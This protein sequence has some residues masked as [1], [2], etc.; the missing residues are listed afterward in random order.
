VSVKEPSNAVK[1]EMARQTKGRRLAP[2]ASLSP[3]NFGLDGLAPNVGN[4]LPLKEAGIQRVHMLPSSR[5]LAALDYL[6]GF[7]NTI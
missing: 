5:V 4:R 3:Q 7:N 1:A 6:N 2:R